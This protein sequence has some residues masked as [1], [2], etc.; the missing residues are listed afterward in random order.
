[1]SRIAGNKRS[2]GSAALRL[3]FPRI[4]A[5]LHLLLLDSLLSQAAFPIS[6]DSTEE[7][8]SC[9]RS[10]F[11]IM[12]APLAFFQTVYLYFQ[13]MGTT[14][15]LARFADSIPRCPPCLST[16][17]VCCHLRFKSLFL[18]LSSRK[19]K[20]WWLRL[21]DAQKNSYWRTGTSCKQ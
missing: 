15:C 18:F 14:S 10:L 8:C 21:T 12:C 20:S 19:Q 16:G 11:L 13:L 17:C 1:M 7:L 5:E 4:C 3:C 6:W 9:R 2:S